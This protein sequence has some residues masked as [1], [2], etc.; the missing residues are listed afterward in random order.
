MVW[1]NSRI[2][3]FAFEISKNKQDFNWKELKGN[4][5]RIK[6]PTFEKGALR[7]VENCLIENDVDRVIENDTDW[8]I[9]NDIDWVIENHID[10][11]IEN[12]ID[13]V[14]ENDIDWVIK[15]RN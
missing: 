8:V 9:K 12:D 6:C 11:V 14:I 10:W 15:I 1:F 3:K 4:E 5:G 7:V 2:P 13:W